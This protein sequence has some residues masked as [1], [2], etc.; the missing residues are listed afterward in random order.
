MAQ[1]E[2]GLKLLDEQGPFDLYFSTYLTLDRMQHFLWRY[3]D[4]GDPTWP[5]P[6]EHQSAILDAYLMFDRIVG[7]YLERADDDTDIIVISDHGHG[8]R[9][10]EVV[11]V[12]EMLRQKG[13]LKVKAGGKNPMHPRRVL[14]QAKRTA[15]ELLDRFDLT[16]YTHR[17][18]KLIPQTRKLK[19][20]SFLVDEAANPIHAPIFAGTNPCGGVNVHASS[21][22]VLGMEYEEARQAVIDEL[23]EQVDPKSGRRLFKWVVRREDVVGTGPAQDRFPDV[24]YLMESGYGTGWDLFGPVV[25]VN[26]THRKISGGHKIDG[27]LYTNFDPSAVQGGTVSRPYEL[28]DVAPLVLQRLG[29]SR[30]EW[31]SEA[32]EE[33]VMR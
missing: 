6:N 7:D 14:Q 10:T 15:M 23:R 11:N 2:Y 24:L 29:L 26:P 3:H 28:L 30:Q 32:L 16:D 17:I 18:A 19:K 9:C 21:I 5:G 1:H 12:N 20:A 13:W 4:E 27:V 22:G 31:M 8:R 25:A 33:T